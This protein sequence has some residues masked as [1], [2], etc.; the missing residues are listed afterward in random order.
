MP[1]CC[2]LISGTLTEEDC[3]KAG[4]GYLLREVKAAIRNPE[5]QVA[6]T[7][8]K[9][10]RGVWNTQAAFLLD[11]A[12]TVLAKRSLLSESADFFVLGYS[13]P[14]RGPSRRHFFK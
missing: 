5:F 13:T 10:G 8:Y 3:R 7:E 4:P 6:A 11:Q 1:V 12:C 2:K 14:E 9:T